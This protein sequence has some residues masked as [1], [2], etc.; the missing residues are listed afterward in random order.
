M[1]G[2]NHRSGQVSRVDSGQASGKTP[3][4]KKKLSAATRSA[5]PA[6]TIE[7]F[8]TEIP[9]IRAMMRASVR[10]VYINQKDAGGYRYQQCNRCT[11]HGECGFARWSVAFEEADSTC[12]KQREEFGHDQ[13][14]EQRPDPGNSF[15]L[16]NRRLIVLVPLDR[17]ALPAHGHRFL[18]DMRRNEE[19]GSCKRRKSTLLFAGRSFSSS[20]QPTKSARESGAFLQRPATTP[21]LLGLSQLPNPERFSSRNPLTELATLI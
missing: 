1:E 21:N 16:G 13:N 5:D 19:Q 12:P 9:P 10:G 15:Y 7:K 2:I 14:E 18:T 4:A 6:A 20:R 17:Q 8:S 3:I 11:H